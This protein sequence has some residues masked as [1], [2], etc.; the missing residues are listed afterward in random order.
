[1]ATIQLSKDFTAIVDDDSVTHLEKYKWHVTN[2][3]GTQR[4]Y[5]VTRMNGKRVRMHRLIW[6]IANGEIPAR[7]EIDHISRDTLDNRLINLRVASR[8]ENNVNSKVRCDNTTG[9]KG[10]YYVKGRGTPYW[11]YVKRNGKR[12]GLGMYKTA[13]E[14]SKAYQQKAKELYGD[15][16]S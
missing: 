1:M 11:A 9:Y 10:V 2:Q 6:E 8:S 3:T 15:F 5:A 12:Y 14:A 4:Y 13:E 7:K 16:A